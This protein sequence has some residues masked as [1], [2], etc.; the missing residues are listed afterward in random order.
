MLEARWTP[1]ANKLGDFWGRLVPII[2][3]HINMDTLCAY[4]REY[5]PMIAHILYVQ[6]SSQ[7][8]A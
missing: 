8:L 1:R 2:E 7:Q 5:R 6:C 3:F 4:F